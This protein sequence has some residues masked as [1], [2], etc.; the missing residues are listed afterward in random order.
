VSFGGGVVYF[1]SRSFALDATLLRTTGDLDRYADGERV[2]GVDA[3][4]VSAT[5]FLIGVRWYP[6]R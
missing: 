2:K 1:L 6:W 3:V 4:D 5:R